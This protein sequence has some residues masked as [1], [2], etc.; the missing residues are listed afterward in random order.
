MEQTGLL[1]I[2]NHLRRTNCALSEWMVSLNDHPVQTEHSSVV[3]ES[4][5]VEW[6][7]EPM[8]STCNW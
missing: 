2:E 6:N 3:P 8:Q 7:D 5:V 1:D 4:D